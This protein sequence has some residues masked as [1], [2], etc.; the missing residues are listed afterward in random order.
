MSRSLHSLLLGLTLLFLTAGGCVLNTPDCP[1][2]ADPSD[3]LTE[4]DLSFEGSHL[5]D[6]ECVCRC[7]N[8]EPFALVRD[9][10]CGEYVGP[11]EDNAGEPRTLVCE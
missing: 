1:C 10:S 2:G 3:T 5:V 9:R 6:D 4:H 7:G 8:D 11:C